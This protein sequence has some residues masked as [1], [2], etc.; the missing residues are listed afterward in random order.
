VDRIALA[1]G[2]LDLAGLTAAVVSLTYLHLA[3]T[4]LSPL[5]N[6]V[7][8]F[9]ITE[10]RAG[11][12]AATVALAVAGLG[13]AIG[14]DKSLH[15]G[16]IGVVVALLVVF[17][18]ARAIIS[19]FPMDEPGGPR[20]PTGHNHGV[21]AIVTFGSATLAAL[22]LGQVLSGG[23]QWHWLS[24]WSTVFGV[25]MALLVIGM[26]SAR[27]NRGLRGYFGLVERGLYLAIIAWLLLLGVVIIVG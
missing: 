21:I 1:G 2:W 18:V 5:R 9:G 24:P 16:G 25:A 23:A 3:P 7:S 17:A 26:A 8:Q 14:L 27:R 15:E 22:R 13:A 10:Y 20:T 12:R 19:W 4:G 6:A 11:Y